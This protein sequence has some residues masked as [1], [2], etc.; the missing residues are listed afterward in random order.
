MRRRASKDIQKDLEEVGSPRAF[1]RMSWDKYLKRYVWDDDKTPYFVPVARMTQAQANSEIFA[2]AL[3]LVVLF[4]VVSVVSLS[5][6]APSGRSYGVSMYAFSVVCGAVVLGAT[7]QYPAALY[8]SAAPAAT[9]G[10]FVLYG[11]PPNLRLADEAL[12]L[13]VTVALLRYGLRV[14]AITKGYEDMP[15]KAPDG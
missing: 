8:C 12:L 10:Y 3:F 9:L 1:G 4:S 13:V 15:G 14:A 2:F 5:D 6:A 11:F 7:R